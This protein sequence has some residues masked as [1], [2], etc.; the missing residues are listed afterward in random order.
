MWHESN[1]RE[2]AC[3]LVCPLT[4]QRAK[5]AGSPEVAA[6][7][8]ELAVGGSRLSSRL[9]SARGLGITE[10]GVRVAT[11]PGCAWQLRGEKGEE[12]TRASTPC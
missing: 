9:R 7:V 5:A 12:R 3:A 8:W 2:V 11:A 1:R 10:P 4:P 6:Q